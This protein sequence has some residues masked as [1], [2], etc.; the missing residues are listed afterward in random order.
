MEADFPDRVKVALRYDNALAHQV[1]AGA[2]LLLMPSRYEPCGLSQ[3][4]AMRYGCI[5]VATRIGGLQDTIVDQP[6]G[7]GQTGFLA[8]DVTIEA[9]AHAVERSIQHYQ[10]TPFWQA[11]QKRAMHQDNSWNRSAQKYLKLYRSLVGG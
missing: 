6:D 2:D 10:D 11:L 5:T 3:L 4:I 8:E 9:I 7:R 1:Y